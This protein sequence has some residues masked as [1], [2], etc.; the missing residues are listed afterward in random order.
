MSVHENG[1]VAGNPV[2]QT[3]IFNKATGKK[4]PLLQRLLNL[5][6]GWSIY[7]GKRSAE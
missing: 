6:W 4:L 1:K 3:F 5:S 7:T 2:S